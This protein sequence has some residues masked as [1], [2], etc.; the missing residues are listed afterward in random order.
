MNFIE[1][2][3]SKPH[4]PRY[5]TRYI[6]FIQ[7]C[8][9]INHPD[10]TTTENHH[11][12]PKSTDL[13]PEYKSFK[14]FPWNKARLTLK[15]HYIAH[16]LLWRAYRGRQTQ[17]FKIMC[18]RTGATNSRQ[19]SLA[20]EEHKLMMTSDKNPNKDGSHSRKYWASQESRDKSKSRM[21]ASWEEAGVNRRSEQAD[22]MAKLNKI[23]KSKPKEERVYKC[24]V[25][26]GIFTRLEF[27]HKPPKEEFVC[28]HK[29]NGVRNGRKGKGKKNPN[30]SIARKG[31]EPWN[32][33][34]SNPQAAENARKG[35]KKL[36]AKVT[37][38]K[39][40]YKEDGTWTWQY[41]KE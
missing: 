25:C 10:G 39:R 29:C 28:G 13:F 12:C 9:E 3:K 40:L 1:L 32:K 38:R 15:Q 4:D 22:L 30:L 27:T 33:G 18:G 8:L 36:S 16:L 23:H 17:A 34:N 35:A 37:G 19:Y 41:P 2:L 21:L 5:L 11:I 14:K 7:K 20:R 31:I 24:V 26:E 6:S